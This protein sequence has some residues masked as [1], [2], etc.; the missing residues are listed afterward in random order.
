MAE[1]K[2]LDLIVVSP[3][4]DP[5]V[6]KILD[7]GK[8]KFEAEK[9]AK[10]AKKK[11]QAPEVK[12][13]KMR[14]KID[15]HDY[16]VKLK[17]IKKFLAEGDKVKIVVMLKGREVQHSH[18]ALDLINRIIQDMEGETF[19]VEKK[20]SMEGKNAIMIFAPAGVA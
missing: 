5:P 9:R 2:G 12:E 18:L 19:V 11:Q 4:Q 1:E 17:N 7:Y 10:D 3:A 13:V 20:A 16:Q 15:K 6:A 14:Y 8:Y